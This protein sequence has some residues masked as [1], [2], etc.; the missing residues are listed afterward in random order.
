MAGLAL[1]YD[2]KILSDVENLLLGTNNIISLTVCKHKTVIPKETPLTFCITFPDFERFVI[3]AIAS[4]PF[5]PGATVMTDVAKWQRLPTV[6][7]WCISVWSRPMTALTAPPNENK[8][9]KKL[10]KLLQ[11]ITVPLYSK[12]I[13]QVWQYYGTSRKAWINIC[14][15]VL[16]LKDKAKSHSGC[17]VSG[18]TPS[19]WQ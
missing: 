1:Y 18:V 13:I 11:S 9:E 8:R 4:S 3:F 2:C 7:L 17:R 14:I 10:V 12:S 19:F 16:S 15:V 6:P 5:I